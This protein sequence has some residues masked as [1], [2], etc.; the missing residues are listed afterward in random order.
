[1]L[2]SVDLSE[3]MFKENSYKIYQKKQ[4]GNILGFCFLT[5]IDLDNI[6][7]FNIFQVSGTRVQGSGNR[8]QGTGIRVQGSGIRQQ[9]TVNCE[10]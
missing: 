9:E 8:D 7:G 3:V 5:F 6:F 10:L 4:N 2:D 1:M